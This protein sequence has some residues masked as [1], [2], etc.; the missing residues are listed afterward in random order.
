MSDEVNSVNP[1]SLSIPL[2]KWCLG[3]L[4]LW[5]SYSSSSSS[6]FLFDHRFFSI[7]GIK[8]SKIQERANTYSLQH[9]PSTSCPECSGLSIEPNAKLTTF[10]RAQAVLGISICFCRSKFVISKKITSFEICHYH[11]CSQTWRESR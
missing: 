1:S 3:T 2:R 10:V 6:T 9:K 11:H 5:S 7:N 8:F 4:E